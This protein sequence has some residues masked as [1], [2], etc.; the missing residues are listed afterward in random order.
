[1]TK[2]RRKPRIIEAYQYYYTEI[3][4]GVVCH[5]RSNQGDNVCGCCGK[6][7]DL[8]GWIASGGP[9]GGYIVC[10]G[11]WV[12][13]GAEGG[14]YACKPDIFE[15]TYE[16]VEDEKLV[17]EH[18]S[19]YFLGMDDSCHWYIIPEDNRE[20]WRIWKSGYNEELD[21]PEFAV[22]ING[23]PCRVTFKDP[24]EGR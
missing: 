24:R 1:M 2:Y 15:N 8:H 3:R 22:R 13:T 9:E 6:I 7:M 20:E 14:C 5:Y 11:D 4:S 19:R 23:F 21:V 10:P 18:E 17:N 12:I 16:L